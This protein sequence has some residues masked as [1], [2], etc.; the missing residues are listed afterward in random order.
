MSALV[1]AL[2]AKLVTCVDPFIYALNQ[3]KIRTETFRRLH[4]VPTVNP[5]AGATTYYQDPGVSVRPPYDNNINNHRN[6]EPFQRQTGVVDGDRSETVNITN[7]IRISS[8]RLNI[9][10]RI[11]ETVP[12]FELGEFVGLAAATHMINITSINNI[13]RVYQET[14]I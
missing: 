3:Q 11:P 12:C 4:L 10:N 9:E 2:F 6:I 8:I 13:D 5:S 1:P 14:S 7:C